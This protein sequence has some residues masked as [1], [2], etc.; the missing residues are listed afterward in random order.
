[1]E[2]NS[3]IYSYFGT[4]KE[5][6]E[7][8]Y[9]PN[10]NLP[11]YD[12]KDYSVICPRSGKSAENRKIEKDKIYEIIGADKFI[13]IGTDG[14]LKDIKSDNITNLIDET[15]ILEA[16]GII[17][18][19]KK[20]IGFQGLMCF[21]AMSH[22]IE[23]EVYLTSDYFESFKIRCPQEWQQYLLNIKFI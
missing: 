11:D 6:I 3:R 5:D 20:F 18:K 15:T 21:V 1:V 7:P 19:S 22:K 17:K 9:F 23:S 13:I 14:D 8:N 4:E 12:Q 10:F 2:L 16:M